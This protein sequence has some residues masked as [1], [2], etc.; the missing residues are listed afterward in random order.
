LDDESAARAA[1]VASRLAGMSTS[2][3]AE[4]QQ[5]LTQRLGADKVAFLKA[6]GQRGSG[7]SASFAPPCAPLPPL[8]PPASEAA[9]PAGGPA[10]VRFA[11]DGALLPSQPPLPPSEALRRDPLRTD[12]DPS[13][14]GYT[15]REAAHLARSSVP[16]QRVVALRLLA[17]ALQR[18]A[19]GMAS[20]TAACASG[21]AP[22]AG[23][24]PGVTWAALW[25]HA[26]KDAQMPLL[27]RTALDDG[28]PAVAA[29]AAGAIAALV[30]PPPA[31]ASAWESWVDAPAMCDVDQAPPAAPHW[32]ARAGAAWEAVAPPGEGAEGESDGDA[33]DPLAALLRMEFAARARFLIEAARNGPAAAPLLRALLAA[34]RHSAAA[35]EAVCATPR[36]LA[37]LNEAFVEAEAPPAAAQRAG[38]AGA[39]AGA[40]AEFWRA[41]PAALRLLRALARA[42]PA[43]ARAV[44]A[45]GAV[46]AAAARFTPLP[47]QQVRPARTHQRRLA[48]SVDASQP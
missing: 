21:C 39:E 18:T 5:E 31:E 12:G 4:A 30:A 44:A 3:I 15:F 16:A 8:R 34:A 45:S 41:R 38:V 24:A 43:A 36:L 10:C 22:P 29:A 33:V 32:R 11:L 7:A 28:A 26:V 37:A 2:E 47:S 6:R 9:P 27:L 48:R 23:P 25:V 20:A 40:E 19:S 13:A 1:D 35:A 42:S 46:A 14:A 17:A